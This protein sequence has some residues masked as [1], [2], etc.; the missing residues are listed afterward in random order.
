MK[1]V[2][3]TIRDFKSVRN[4]TQV[5]V[6]DVTCLVGKNE[7]GKTAILQALY[8]LNPVVPEHAPFDVTDEYPRAEVEEYLQQVESEEATPAIVV[9]AKYVLDPGEI[10]GVEA[11][12]GEGVLPHP[13]IVLSKGYENKLYIRLKLNETVAVKALVQSH[14]L[15]VEVAQGASAC[16]TLQTLK[17]FLEADAQDRQQKHAEAK[18]QAEAL[19]D[20]DAKTKAI[21][22]ADLLAESEA[23]KKL[24]GLLTAVLLG[25]PSIY[26]WTHYLKTSW[27][28]F[29][30][31]DEYYQMEGHVNIEKLKERQT[32][33]NSQKLKPSDLP[34]LGLIEL[35]RLNLDQLLNP[36]RTEE[37]V[38]KLEGAS[39]HLSKQILKFWSQ[40]VSSSKVGGKDVH[41][42]VS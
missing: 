36:Q 38:A 7:S 37:L 22:E 19:T 39:N 24:K 6:G 13:E 17:D 30:Y 29:L 16:D 21:H 2:N 33:Q 23:G 40:R 27:P 41:F 18:A 12:F 25:P 42:G 9:E 26:V 15:P 35:A 4:S 11:V 31:F 1:L 20:A 5:E 14:K 32:G 34:M 3:F 28:K 10:K 8:K